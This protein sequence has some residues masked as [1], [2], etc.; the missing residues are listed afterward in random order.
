MP[1]LSPGNGLPLGSRRRP[2][3]WRLRAYL[4]ASLPLFPL[5]QQRLVPAV[6]AVRSWAG[7]S[8][9]GRR[10]SLQPTRRLGSTGLLSL[11]VDNQYWHADPHEDHC[12]GTEAGEE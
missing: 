10:R 7:H 1:C 9:I 2:A 5:P 12:T 8:L 6:P 4:S 3:W 11:G